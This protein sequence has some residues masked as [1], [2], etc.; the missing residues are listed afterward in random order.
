MRLP[1]PVDAVA[2]QRDVVAEDGQSLGKALGDQKPVE[3]IAVVEGEPRHDFELLEAYREDFYA[4]CCRLLERKLDEW[5]VETELS[6]AELDRNFPQ[7][8]DAHQRHVA[9][10][11]NQVTRYGAQSRTIVGSPQEG[12]RVEQESHHDKHADAWSTLG[13]LLGH[14]VLESLWDIVEIFGHPD[15]ALKA[16]NEST[17]LTGDNI[18]RHQGEGA[19]V[20]AHDNHLL[21]LSGFGEKVGELIF[22]FVYRYCRHGA[23]IRSP[24]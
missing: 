18:R 3:R 5:Y 4:M 16:A 13:V 7:A 14:V 23:S 1:E 19:A 24:A 22:G 2:V 17:P 20:I 12:M 6:S 10:I 8:D 9:G 15:L 11:F 21:A